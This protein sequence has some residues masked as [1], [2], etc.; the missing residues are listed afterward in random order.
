MSHRAI[1]LLSIFSALA[2]IH[3]DVALA[4]TAH[5][6]GELTIEVVD[7]V[8]GK[9]IAARMHLYMGRNAGPGAGAKRPVKLNIPGSAEFGGHFYI[10]GKA[11]LPLRTGGY[12]FELEAGPEYITQSG[13][14]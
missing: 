8:T 13:H 12:T 5:P 7:S 3:G 11:T 14:F 4:A 10:D 6:D 2:P 1:L 9:P